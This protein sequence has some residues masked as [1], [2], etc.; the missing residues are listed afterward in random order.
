MMLRRLVP[1]MASC[2]SAL[3]VL[4]DAAGEHAS[5]RFLE[6]F[7]ANNRYPHRRRAYAGAAEGSLA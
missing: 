1:I 2:P 6:F 7:G 5:V 4:V 3:L